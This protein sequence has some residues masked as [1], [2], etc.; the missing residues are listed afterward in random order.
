MDQNQTRA[1]VMKILSPEHK[2]CERITNCYKNTFKR[3][4]DKERNSDCIP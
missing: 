3:I 4:Y 1:F 2:Y